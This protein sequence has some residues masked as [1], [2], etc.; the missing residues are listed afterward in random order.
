MIDMS[1]IDPP[2]AAD[3]PAAACGRAQHAEAAAD[4]HTSGI[5]DAP[6]SEPQRAPLSLARRELTDANQDLAAD[7]AA[8]ERCRQPVARLRRLMGD[9]ADAEVELEDKRREFLSIIGG[10]LG[11]GALPPRPM[12]PSDLVD[13]EQRIGRL[14]RDSAAARSA[15]PDHEAVQAAAHRQLLQS[16]ARRNRALTA[17]IL[18]SVADYLDRQYVPTMRTAREHEKTIWD[19]HDALQPNDPQTAQ[20]I[21]ELIRLRKSQLSIPKPEPERGAA[22]LAALACDPSAPLGSDP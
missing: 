22:W 3:A 6:A 18:E 16:T 2:T 14:Q 21:A 8:F 13:L 19:I 20:R 17:A 15:M 11:A 7:T 5:D 12:E 4:G 9:C 1:Y 10:W